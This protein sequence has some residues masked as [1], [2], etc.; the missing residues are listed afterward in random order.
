M[1]VSDNEN[2]NKYPREI[3]ETA[4]PRRKWKGT[5]WNPNHL[6]G[7]KFYILCSLSSIVSRVSLFVIYAVCYISTTAKHFNF[8]HSWYLS[9]MKSEASGM[10][11]QEINRN[12]GDM[13]C[14]HETSNVN[15]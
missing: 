5:K 8:L 4:T 12:Y 15:G 11:G 7:M 3:Q 13:A 6:H 9:S 14:W 1:S 2:E 10:A